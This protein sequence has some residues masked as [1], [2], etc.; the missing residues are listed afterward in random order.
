MDFKPR[1]RQGALPT[2][3]MLTEW[4][5]KMVFPYRNANNPVK[6]ETKAIFLLQGSPKSHTEGEVPTVSPGLPTPTP[7]P[8]QSLWTWTP[9][10]RSQRCWERPRARPSL[11]QRW[12][13]G[14]RARGHSPPV[15]SSASLMLL[16]SH[17]CRIKLPHYKAA[18]LK[19]IFIN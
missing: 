11:S 18:I 13:G 8:W 1:L 7:T 16:N 10:L 14:C 6:R 15:R 19:N 9:M 3:K 2:S 4:A 17:S 12:V 5:S